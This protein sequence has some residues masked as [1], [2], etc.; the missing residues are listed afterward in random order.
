MWKIPQIQIHPLSGDRAPLL[1]TNHKNLY[2]LTFLEASFNSPGRLDCTK[3]WKL[4]A[5][6]QDTQV[7][8]HKVL[9][10]FPGRERGNYLVI[11]FVDRSEWQK[12]EA[13]IE[14]L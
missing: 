11:V 12:R 13:I 2:P 7:W 3:S 14:K 8:E 10:V 1:S 5:W 9:A 4:P 6:G